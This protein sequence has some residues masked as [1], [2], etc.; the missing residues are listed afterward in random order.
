[1]SKPSMRSFVGVCGTRPD[2]KRNGRRSGARLYWS[3]LRSVQAELSGI[4]FVNG[5]RKTVHCG[6]KVVF[7]PRDGLWLWGLMSEYDAAVDAKEKKVKVTAPSPVTP[8]VPSSMTPALVVTPLEVI[9]LKQEMAALGSA[10]LQ[11]WQRRYGQK[12]AFA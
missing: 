8:T 7:A 5:E 11:K 1:M 6:Q 10:Q 9:N 4:V 2:S 12:R 3:Q